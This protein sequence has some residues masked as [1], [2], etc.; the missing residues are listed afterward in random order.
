MGKRLYV[1]YR[2]SYSRS[3]SSGS[4]R[5]RNN[6]R[7]RYSRDRKK[8]PMKRP[9]SSDQCFI[10]REY[11][12]WYLIIILKEIGPKIVEAEMERVSN[13]GSASCVGIRGILPG[14]VQLP[15][16]KYSYSNFLERMVKREFLG[17][18]V[19]PKKKVNNFYKIYAY[20]S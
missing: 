10:C 13:L 1:D 12:H 5:N 4:Y 7:R 16:S 17:R 3:S 11:G 15:R 2:S 19:D 18:G 20:V 8:R 9:R 14:N 6:R